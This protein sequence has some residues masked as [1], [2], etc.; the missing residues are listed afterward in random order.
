LVANTQIKADDIETE[1][2]GKLVG[3]FLRQ[4]VKQGMPIT[5]D[6]VDPQP[7]PPEPPMFAVMVPAPLGIIQQRHI[8]KNSAVIIK[9]PGTPLVISG[10]VHGLSCDAKNCNVIVNLPKTPAQ[11]IDGA[12]LIGADLELQTP[13]SLAKP[14]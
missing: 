2:T 8:E 7:M 5:A 14:P 1:Q 6:M 4:E 12:T 9:L 3:R 11:A 10:K 13:P